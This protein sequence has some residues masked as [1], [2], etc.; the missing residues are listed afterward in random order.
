MHPVNLKFQGVSQNVTAGLVC[1]SS[2]DCLTV[3]CKGELRKQW[4][5]GL[6]SSTEQCTDM[7]IIV[8]IYLSH[9]FTHMHVQD[10]K[11]YLI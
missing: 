3:F 6:R 2:P 7:I 5:T 11:H 1:S 10:A 9:F 4:D 8:I